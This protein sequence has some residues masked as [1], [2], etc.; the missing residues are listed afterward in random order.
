MALRV[1]SAA[2]VGKRQGVGSQI[3][4]DKFLSRKD[5]RRPI[6]AQEVGHKTRS[7]PPTGG[8]RT[9]PQQGDIH[10]FWFILQVSAAWFSFLGN[11][12]YNYP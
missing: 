12:L 11:M 4:F 6:P 7:L 5:I 10:S 3:S 2:P 1:K 8:G 9:G